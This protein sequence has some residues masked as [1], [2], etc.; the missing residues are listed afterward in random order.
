MTNE[1]LH[2]ASHIPTMLADTA[3]VAVPA[4]T[5]LTGNIAFGIQGGLG[6]LGAAIGAGVAGSKAAE[7]VGRNPAAFG[8]IL[9]IGILGMAFAEAVAFYSLYLG[10]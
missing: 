6:C 3:P 7:A 1:I 4:A 8:K 9:V 2:L 5:G 10:H